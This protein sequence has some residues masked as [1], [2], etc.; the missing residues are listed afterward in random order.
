M[1]MKPRQAS[2]LLVS[3]AVVAM[4]V[5]VTFGSATS[6]QAETLTIWWNKGYFQAEDEALRTMVAKWEKQ[7]GNEVNLSF[8]S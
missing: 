6:A 4:G 2:A 1:Q 8:Y 5:A 3:C 7:T